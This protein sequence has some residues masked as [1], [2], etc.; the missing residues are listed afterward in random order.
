MRSILVAASWLTFTAVESVAI[1][2]A[3]IDTMAV[4]MISSTND[5]PR[6]RS[7]SG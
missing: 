7:G 3:I 4:D 1:A 5:S 2:T 6:R